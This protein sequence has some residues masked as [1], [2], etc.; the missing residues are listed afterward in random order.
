MTEPSQYFKGRTVQEQ[1]NEVIGYVD[2][3]A[4]E[5]ATTAIASDVAQV[6][7]DM[8]D[9]D[10][11]ASAAAASAAAAA[12]TLANAVKKTGEASQSIAGNIAVAGTLSGGSIS[13]GAGGLGV[14][15]H[16]AL[17][18]VTVSG[19]ITVPTPTANGY[20]A[21]KKYVDDA[22]ALKADKTYVDAQDALKISITD[23][24]SYAVGLTGNQNVSGNKNMTVGMQIA[25]LLAADIQSNTWYKVAKLEPTKYFRLTYNI[26]LPYNSTQYMIMDVMILT[27]RAADANKIVVAPISKIRNVLTDTQYI[28]V[29]FDGSDFYLYIKTSSATHSSVYATEATAAGALVNAISAITPI[30]PVAE[31]PTI[32]TYYVIA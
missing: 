11:D 1:M 20:A 22:D 5:V 19:N 32:N 7:Q 18:Y 13:A 10:A 25:T 17:R 26:S 6:H 4:A 15:G 2:T 3:R 14:G 8:L 30:T 21:N 9:A 23:I 28:G 31:D 16:S 24:N 29:G 27:P 12:G